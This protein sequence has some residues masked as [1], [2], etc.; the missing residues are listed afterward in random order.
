M[1]SSSPLYH[2]NVIAQTLLACPKLL[3]Q[4]FFA[5]L[6]AFGTWRVSR[7]CSH[8]RRCCSGR[9]PWCWRSS[10]GC[11]KYHRCQTVDQ[12]ACSLRA[13]SSSCQ[14]STQRK[15]KRS[16]HPFILQARLAVELGWKVDLLQAS[17]NQSWKACLEVRALIAAPKSSL[18]SFAVCSVARRRDCCAS[19]QCFARTLHH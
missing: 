16:R 15:Q 17:L 7:P 11:P 9:W 3:S 13:R 6:M 8:R 2:S 12:A 18:L 10:Q 19:S 4:S 1:I 14:D 5:T